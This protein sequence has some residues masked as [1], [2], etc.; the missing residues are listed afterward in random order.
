VNEETVVAD[1]ASVRV[2]MWLGWTEADP[3]LPGG[4]DAFLRGRARALKD[5]K[6]RDPAELREPVTFG[7]VARDEKNRRYRRPSR[8]SVP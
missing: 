6:G 5:G 8:R 7:V 2:R 1:P 4:A 3:D